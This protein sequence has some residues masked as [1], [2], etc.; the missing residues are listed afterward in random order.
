MSLVIGKEWRGEGREKEEW[1]VRDEGDGMMKI[2]HQTWGASSS[3]ES[4]PLM[5]LQTFLALL[6]LIWHMTHT[7]LR[8]YPTSL[9]VKSSIKPSFLL[10]PIFPWWVTVFCFMTHFLSDLSSDLSYS[11]QCCYVA[12]SSRMYWLMFWPILEMLLS[13]RCFLLYIKRLTCLKERAESIHSQLSCL[14]Q[15]LKLNS[16]DYNIRIS[17]TLSSSSKHF[18]YIIRV[19]SN[20]VISLTSL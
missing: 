16:L 7:A 12:E 14:Q 19:C 17:H 18:D 20:Y 10:Y 8:K 2:Q 4:P 1:F 15:D 6:T 5:I 9:W 11:Y 13:H 3:Q